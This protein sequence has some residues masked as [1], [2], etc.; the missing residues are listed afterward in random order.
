MD[1]CIQQ[2]DLLGKDVVSFVNPDNEQQLMNTEIRRNPSH[3]DLVFE[4][5]GAQDMDDLGGSVYFKAA[6]SK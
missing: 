1:S 4:R 3:D 6:T 5:I 2:Q